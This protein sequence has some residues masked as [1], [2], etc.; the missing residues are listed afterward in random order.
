MADEHTTR[1][2]RALRRI[3]S[4]NKAPI[5]RKVAEYALKPSVARRTINVKSI[6]RLTG[7]GDVV[8]F[9][10]KVLGTGSMSH[11]VSLF[12]FG[13]SVSAASKVEKAG[14][15]IISHNTITAERPTGSGVVLLG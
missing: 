9:P 3:S 8:V 2:A 12:C 15:R 5:W 14:G 6:D 1:M 13:I 11:P 7:D 4:E 10:G